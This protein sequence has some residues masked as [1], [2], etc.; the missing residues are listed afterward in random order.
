MRIIQNDGL[1]YAKE[2][3][4]GRVNNFENVTDIST[5]GFGE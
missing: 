5:Q 1:E 2:G 3:F 4:Y